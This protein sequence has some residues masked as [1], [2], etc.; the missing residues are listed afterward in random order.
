MNDKKRHIF[1]LLILFSIMLIFNSCNRNTKFIEGTCLTDP[2]KPAKGIELRINVVR[3]DGSFNKYSD[4]LD[5]TGKY[6][7]KV[8]EDGFRIIDI[9]LGK[10]PYEKWENPRLNRRRELFY[11]DFVDA[12]VYLIDDIYLYEPLKIINP[13]ENENVTLNE[14]F[15]FKWEQSDLAEYYQLNIAKEFE[16]KPGELVLQVVNINQNYLHY[17]TIAESDKLSYENYAA[18]SES[19]LN[20]FS[21]IK[22]GELISGKYSIRVIGYKWSGSNQRVVRENSLNKDHIVYIDF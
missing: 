16:D 13:S 22:Y 15:I 8:K 21:V 11:I 4:K 17:K 5:S 20:E 14:D 9:S 18:K 2:V 1:K 6:K 19:D 10:Y 7:V 12:G 3:E